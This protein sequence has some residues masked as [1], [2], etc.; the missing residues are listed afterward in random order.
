MHKM[1]FYVNLSC[2]EANCGERFGSVLAFLM[3]CLA[4]FSD[5]VG[6]FWPFFTGGLAFFENINMTTLLGV[7]LTSDGSWN[8]ESDR[9]I[10]KANA[11]LR[12]PYCSVVTKREISNTAKLSVFKLVFVPILTYG[13]ESYVTT[14]RILSK[15]TNGRDGNFATSPLS[16]FSES[17][18]PSYCRLV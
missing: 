3:E 10:A 17:R 16:H 2:V 15:R 11:V 12:E 5:V 8:K 7:V 14:E 13:H 9:R 6:R 18:D 4:F 1:C